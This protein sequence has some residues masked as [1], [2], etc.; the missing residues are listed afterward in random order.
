MSQFRKLG[1]SF[2]C[3]YYRLRSRKHVL[4]VLLHLICYIM[5][6]LNVIQRAPLKHRILSSR[7]MA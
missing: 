5:V 6:P 1:Y 2:R 7:K 4:C 3:H